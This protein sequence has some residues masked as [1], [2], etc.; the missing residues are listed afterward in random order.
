VWPK[1][2]F[3]AAWDARGAFTLSV[4]NRGS[5]PAQIERQRVSVDGAARR[6]WPDALRALTGKPQVPTPGID[7][8]E[9]TLSPGQEVKFLTLDDPGA[10]DSFTQQIQRLTVEACYCSTLDDCWTLVSAGEDPDRTVPERDCAPDRRP[11]VPF[12]KGDRVES[13]APVAATGRDARP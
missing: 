5:G 10:A 9:T 11:F 4:Q 2:V 7:T 6:S 1:L 8:L 3:H 13:A 12:E